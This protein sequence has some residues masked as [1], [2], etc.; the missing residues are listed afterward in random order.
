VKKPENMWKLFGT[1]FLILGTVFLFSGVLAQMGILHPNPASQGDPKVWFPI[2]GCILLIFGMIMCAV[3]YRKEKVR[4]LLLCE[5]IETKGYITCVKQLMFTRWN[6]LHP[7]VV[8][9]TYE[10][11]G[12]SYKGKSNLLWSQPQVCEQSIVT[13]YVDSQNPAHCAVDL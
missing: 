2:L 10:A 12:F 3:S 7:Y 1:L 9:F 11:E 5:G 4:K 6:G 13:V 8:C